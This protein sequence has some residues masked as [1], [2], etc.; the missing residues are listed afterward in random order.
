MEEE[1]LKENSGKARKFSL[2]SKIIGAAVV[3]IG[4]VFKWVG[5]FQNCEINEL[6]TVGFTIM[7]IFGTIDLNIALDKFTQK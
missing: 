6:C 3:L 4:A 1:K 5:W 2:I 7:G